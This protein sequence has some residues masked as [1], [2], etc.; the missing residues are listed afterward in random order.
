M[1]GAI[2]A[3]WCIDVEPDRTEP[4]AGDDAWSGFV[5][6]VAFVR[7]LRAPLEDRTGH[8]VRVT[9][10]LRMDPMIEQVYGSSDYVVAAYPDLVDEIRAHG[11]AIGLHIHPF[12][13]DSER[14]RWYTEHVDV[15]WLRHCFATATSSYESTFG[16]PASIL[17]M[18]GYMLDDVVIDLAVEYG[19]QVDVTAEP[20]LAPISN[21]Y[22]HGAYS[23]APS[24]DFR[25]FPRRRH[26]PGRPILLIPLTAADYWRLGRGPRVAVRRLRR[27]VARP[28]PYHLPLSPWR[29]WPSADAYWGLV[30]SATRDISD[31]HIAFAIRTLPADDRGAR[32]SYAVLRG[33]ADHPIAP[34]L[35]FVN[36]TTLIPE[37]QLGPDTS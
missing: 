33:L 2:P 31:P 32:N 5:D 26:Q 9:W 28:G 20:G 10:S 25:S 4:I 21:D 36:P 8:P 1:A 6:A 13:W 18:G 14:N 27:R 37:V 34:Q 17:R 23:N 15:E 35:R 7:E 24:T 29:S 30:A 11:D 16:E 22:S 19:F 3:V 12:R